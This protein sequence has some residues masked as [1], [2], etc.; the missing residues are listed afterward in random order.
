[1]DNTTI[2]LDKIQEI[3]QHISQGN[4]DIIIDQCGINVS[5]IPALSGF[6]PAIKWQSL[7]QGL[8]ENIYPED[9]PLLVR[10]ELSDIQQ[11][12]WLYALA[13]EAAVTAP[14]LVLSSSWPFEALAGWL[15]RC[16]DARHEGRPGIFRFWDTRLFSFLFT[17]VLDSEQTNQLHRPVLFWSWQDRDGKP[18]LLEGNGAGLDED[19]ACEPTMFTDSQFESLMCL[20]DA[21]Q[22]LGY[23]PLPQGLFNSEEIAFT[24][25]FEAMLSATHEKILFDDK[26]DKWVINYLAEQ[27]KP[28][29]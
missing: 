12:Q 18:A 11:V 15:T 8:P 3:C 13:H 28:T 10:I 22:F 16:V 7:Y 19:E 29:I 20:C 14:L 9:A 4:I 26:R 24:A 21:K 25:C 17:H 1:M 2:W 27:K 6:S 5:V 23:Q